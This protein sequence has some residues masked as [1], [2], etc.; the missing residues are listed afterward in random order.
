MHETSK[1]FIAPLLI[2]CAAVCISGYESQDQTMINVYAVVN[3]VCDQGMI[4]VQILIN[5]GY[6]KV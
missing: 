2:N 1:T 5:D 3:R 6:N 4:S